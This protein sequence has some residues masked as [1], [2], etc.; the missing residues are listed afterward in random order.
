MLRVLHVCDYCRLHAPELKVE[1]QLRLN[2]VQ[3][4][5]ALMQIDWPQTFTNDSNRKKLLIVATCSPGKT[6]GEWELGEPNPASNARDLLPVNSRLSSFWALVLPATVVSK[7]AH[8]T[9]FRA[10]CG[11]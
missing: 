1:L 11:A 2:L 9:E 4:P 8:I 5:N 6:C 7:L 3:A 10:H